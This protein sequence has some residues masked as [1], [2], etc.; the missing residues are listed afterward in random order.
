MRTT[1]KKSNYLFPLAQGAF[2]LAL[3]LILLQTACRDDSFFDGT[4]ELSFSTDTLRFDTVFTELG[5]ATRF[6]RIFNE[7]S[8]QLLIENITLEGGSESFFR[9]NVDGVPGNAFTDVVI[10]PR[11]SLYIFVEVTIDPDNPLTSSPFII[12]D[13][14][15]MNLGGQEQFVQLEAWGQNANYI[16]AINEAGAITQLPCQGG[17]TVWDDPKPYVV[18]GILFIDDC[19]LTIAPGTQIYVHGG[20]VSDEELG[21]YNDGLL[22]VGPNGSIHAQGT[23]EDTIVFQGDRLEESFQDDSGQWQGLRFLEE[24]E[25]NIFDYTTIKNSIFGM[26]L[27]SLAEAKVDHSR[28]MNTSNAGLINIHSKMEMNNSLIHSNGGPAVQCIYGGEYEFN[29]CT[30]A[31]YGND[32]E[33]FW[34]NNFLCRDPLQLCFEFSV[35]PLN[36]EITNSI[37]VGSQ[38]DELILDDITF[39]APGNFNYQF[40][41]SIVRVDELLDSIPNFFDNCIDCININSSD[42]DT[43]FV[44]LDIQDYH[45]DTMSVAENRA[46]P[47]SNLTDDLDAKPRDAVSPDIGCYEFQ[48]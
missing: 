3:V 8:K 11:D 15:L 10:P 14:I 6:V 9:M 22:L 31:S 12:E 25:D 29:Y 41:N 17:Q 38:D 30:F 37:I 42:N 33:A 4:T 43:L 36:A 16:P 2:L 48:Q 24:S 46:I 44:D 28:I 34:L 47:L 21:V 19:T 45:L 39:G 1:L 23:V 7:E 27:D 40:T 35:N 18:Y 13:K 26:W 20:V 5:S 32:V